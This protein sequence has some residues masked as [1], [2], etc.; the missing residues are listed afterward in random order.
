MT[1]LTA[2]WQIADYLVH[3][4]VLHDGIP[5]AWLDVFPQ[6]WR[7]NF[8]DTSDVRVSI[9]ANPVKQCPCEDVNF[10]V[11]ITSGNNEQT[12][13]IELHIPDSRGTFVR[14]QS[15]F[16]GRF[17]VSKDGS[18]GFVA[19]L[20]I[21]LAALVDESGGLL[22]HASGVW[23]DDGIWLFCGPSG[24]GKTTIATELNGE[25]EAF[26]EDRIVLKLDE[27]GSPVVHATPFG[28]SVVAP[29][30]PAHGRVAGIAL[31]EQAQQ[32][33]VASITTMEAVAALFQASRWYSTS[34]FASQR[35][36]NNI[37][38]IIGSCPCFRLKFAR[39]ERFWEF[40]DES[41]L[42]FTETAR[43]EN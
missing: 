31:I 34:T 16:H 19:T 26:S 11:Q 39:D 21:G 5:A 14:N 32:P 8:P 1:N 33:G 29:D 30:C 17:D 9:D 10:G 28:D 27:D 18:F 43:G 25:G 3:A 22:L 7:C 40:L 24:A 13:R 4:R 36:L 20:Q 23:R 6:R 35:T 37:E 12:Q 42:K 15:G 2:F 38:R 41:K